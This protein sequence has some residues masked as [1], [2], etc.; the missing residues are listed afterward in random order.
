MQLTFENNYVIAV[1]VFML[2]NALLQEH[3]RVHTGMHTCARTCASV[4]LCTKDTQRCSA[5]RC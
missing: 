5:N 4:L 1:V 2:T 3:A